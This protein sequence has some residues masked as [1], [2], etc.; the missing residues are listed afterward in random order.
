ML[1]SDTAEFLDELFHEDLF[2]D[3]LS[4]AYDP[5]KAKE[6]YEKTKVLKGRVKGTTKVVAKTSNSS[7]ASAAKKRASAAKAQAARSAA[8]KAAAEKRVFALK[9]RLQQMEEALDKL[10]A[11]AKARSGV[12]PKAS[13]PKAA[14]A[15]SKA[16]DA[17]PLTAAQKREAAKKAA[18][19]REKESDQSLSTQEKTLE[20]KIASVR[21]RIDKMKV[22]MEVARQKTQGRR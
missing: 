15:A 11:Q 16:K 10:A 3:E 12:D 13:A 21:K 5:V 17:K 4:H 18:E 9:V 14:T 22:D 19:R 7:S 2:L 20:A 6:Y 1:N 8:L